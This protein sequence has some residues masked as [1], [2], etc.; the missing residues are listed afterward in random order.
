MEQYDTKFIPN[1]EKMIA[2]K[3]KGATVKIEIDWNSFG[4]G[5]E[6]SKTI[7][8]LTNS[9]AVNRSVES[10]VGALN[11]VCADDLG[12]KTVTAKLKTLRVVHAKDAD[13]PTFKVEKGVAMFLLNATKED[14]LWT[15]EVQK[16]IESNL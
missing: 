1:F 12:Q 2:E 11:N 4:N 13:K 3:C 6:V 15:Q 16:T 5:D 10:F 14:S 9:N 8:A 7:E